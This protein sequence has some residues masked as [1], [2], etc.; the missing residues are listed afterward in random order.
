[1]RQIDRAPGLCNSKLLE[2][3]RALFFFPS[4]LF[5]FSAR[6]FRLKSFLFF[7][8]LLFL[9]PP[10]STER[11]KGQLGLR[12]LVRLQMFRRFFFYPHAPCRDHGASSFFFP[13]HDDRFESSS[14]S[15]EETRGSSRQSTRLLSPLRLSIRR[16]LLSSLPVFS[17]LPTRPKGCA[18]VDKM[19]PVIRRLRHRL[20]PLFPISYTKGRSQGAG[21]LPPPSPPPF[22][23]CGSRQAHAGVLTAERLTH[24]RGSGRLLFFFLPS[25]RRVEE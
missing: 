21:I 25:P 2:F 1:M 24:S 22:F 20:F 10:S 14:S 9:P 7:F 11:G 3:P 16:G 5:A 6:R 18:F 17:R 4:F 8:F 19:F 15:L 23:S 12:L 13:L